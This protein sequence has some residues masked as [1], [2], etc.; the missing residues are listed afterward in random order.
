MKIKLIK[1]AI[2]PGSS[3]LFPSSRAFQDVA[4]PL[5]AAFTPEKHTIRIVD[6]LFA[7]DAPMIVN[8]APF[9]RF[10]DIYT[11]YGRSKKS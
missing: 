6:E 9:L 7:P 11:G 2:L 1:P 5:L 10:V 3:S 4:L 8:S